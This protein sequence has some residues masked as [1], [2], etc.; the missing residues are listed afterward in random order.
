MRPGFEVFFEDAHR[1]LAEKA[2]K[3][4][5]E[6]EPIFAQS[7]EATACREFVGK[8]GRA[9]FLRYVV[10]AAFGGASAQI[11]LR[12]LC[13]IR[14]ALA[15][16][17]GIGDL[18]FAMQGLGSYPI[19]LAGSPEMRRKYL[20]AVAAGEAIAAFAVT[21][22]EAGSDVAAMRTTAV[23]GRAEWILDGTKTFIS[24]AGIADYYVVFAKTDAEAGHKGISAFVVDKDTKGFSVKRKIEITSPHPIGEVAFEGCRVPAENLLGATGDGFKISMQ[25]L[26]LLR[27]SVGAA[28]LG[29]ARRAIDEATSYAKKRKQFG[30]SLGELQSVQ[31]DIAQMETDWEAARL[32][33]YRSAWV[34][35]KGAERVTKESAMAK[36]FATEAAQ[37][38]IDRAVQIHGGLGVTRGV[39]VERLYRE[40]RPLRIYE[41]TSEILK[42]VIARSFLEEKKGAK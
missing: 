6:T 15:Y 24:N 26:D 13:L 4:A 14:E 39:V 7:D 2:V 3:F 12:S 28:A 10:P 9:G 17:H 33:V 18:L 1:D 19:T 8:M 11:D 31:F 27:T 35:D 25:T 5:A 41:G 37:R 23:R 29:L 36:M 16:Q 40:I 30:K 34:K 38:I 42:L 22:T 20:G 21:E 32:L